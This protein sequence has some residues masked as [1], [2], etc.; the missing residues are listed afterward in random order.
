MKKLM[1]VG[2]V[3]VAAIGLFAADEDRVRWTGA[4]DSCWNKPSNWTP[5]R[6]PTADD[7][8]V[9][10][11]GADQSA[12][13]TVDTGSTTSVK[14]ID[15]VT[16]KITLT[17]TEGSALRFSATAK[18][19]YDSGII[20]R[21]G[22]ELLLECPLDLDIRFDTWGEGTV[23]FRSSI[24]NSST[25]SSYLAAMTNIF[26]TGTASFPSTLSCGL[27]GTDDG[28]NRMLVKVTGDAVL[29]V[30]ELSLS[31]NKAHVPV[32]FVIDGENAKVTTT[33][34]AYLGNYATN[35]S[36]QRLYV[37]NGTLTVGTDAF[38]GYVAKGAL[39][40]E[41]GAVTVNGNFVVGGTEADKTR[42]VASEGRVLVSGGT[43]AVGGYCRVGDVA[44]SS[45]LQSGGTVTV[46]NG[47]VLK[48]LATAATTFR[49][50]GGRF[51][52]SGAFTRPLGDA[53]GDAAFELA[54]GTFAVMTADVK[55]LPQ[56]LLVDGP[57][58][59]EVAS[60]KLVEIKRP[61]VF[62]ENAALVKAGA[63]KLKF[64]ASCDQV[65]GS[66]EIKAG[67]LFVS[68]SVNLSAPIGWDEPLDITVRN[69]GVL[70]LHK[71]TSR[72]LMPVDLTVDNGG[73]VYFTND[74]SAYNRGFLN[75]R[76]YT[77]EGESK[78]VGRYWAAPGATTGLKGLA[79][80]SAA[81]T[82]VWT[83][84]AG[85]N[86]W[87][88]PGNWNTG[89]V[90][91]GGVSPSADISA[92]TEIELDKE[93][94]IGCIVFTPNGA[95]RKVRLTGSQKL[96][97]C[98]DASYACGMFVSPDAEIELDVDFHR[99]NDGT[100]ALMGGGT[101]R[102]RKS[103][104]AAD[105]SGNPLLTYD[106]QPIFEGVKQLNLLSGKSTYNFLTAFS[107]ASECTSLLTIGEGTD[108]T[109][110]SLRPSNNGYT[111]WDGVRQVGGKATFTGSMAW[112]RH[113]GTART[114][115][116]YILEGGELVGTDYSMGT[117]ISSS[118]TRYPGAQFVM[119]GGSATFKTI[120]SFLHQ[121][122]ARL[123][124]GT[125]T[126]NGAGLSLN[127][128]WAGYDA[129]EKP[130]QL[131]GVT[132]VANRTDA[133]SATWFNGNV[134]LTGENGDTKIIC[135][136]AKNVAF[137]DGSVTGP[138]G[139]VKEGAKT[140]TF[141]SGCAF[142]GKIEVHEASC[143][144][145]G[146]FNGPSAILVTGGKFVFNSG[147]TAPKSPETI[148]LAATSSLEINDAAITLTVKRLTIA[149]VDQAPGEYAFKSGKVVVAR[150]SGT[151]AGG[152]GGN[153]SDTANWSGDVPDSS[154]SFVSPVDGGAIAINLDQAASL[155]ALTCDMPGSAELTVSGENAMTFPDGAVI[156]VAA[157]NALTLDAPVRVGGKVRKVG[158]GSIAFTG[159]IVA[160][161]ADPAKADA[162]HWLL[163]EDG[164][165]T[166]DCEVAGVRMNAGSASNQQSPSLTLGA[167]ADI[168]A[169]SIAFAA[170]TSDT[171]M[172]GLSNGEIRQTGGV[173]DY[174]N[175]LPAGMT[176]YGAFSDPSGGSARY[177]L[178]GGTLVTRNAYGSGNEDSLFRSSGGTGAGTMEFVQ[179]GGE[180]HFGILLI[181]RG[182]ASV[183]IVTLNGGTFNLRSHFGAAIGCPAYVN[184]NGGTFVSALDG[185]FLGFPVRTTIGGTVGFAQ[186]GT[187]ISSE[188]GADIEGSGAIVQKGPG[189]LVVSGKAEGVGSYAVE[190][191]ALELA[192]ATQPTNITVAAG[193]QLILGQRA[194]DAFDGTCDLAVASRLNAPFVCGYDGLAVVKSLTVGGKEKGAGYYDATLHRVEQSKACLQV[195]T[196]NGPGACIL[197]R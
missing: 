40:Q 177:V 157:G 85:D 171:G 46:G 99:S 124:G 16:G 50:E 48:T 79:A 17:A 195:L 57:A 138:G 10:S 5:Q 176:G 146:A 152:A 97:L 179:N 13:V 42:T 27:S 123:T 80:A 115:F 192:G 3:A 185:T 119:T 127:K 43:L 59:I 24:V 12:T 164:E 158:G 139:I 190:S 1:V 181:G 172:T 6:V 148:D 112:T 47:L 101:I 22:M 163:I 186:T 121:D 25:S 135:K 141:G 7:V 73:L 78:P 108:F 197:I 120:T 126:L 102:A 70:L 151:W 92:A 77:L 4:T 145:S 169:N 117:E 86:K 137:S 76:S 2:L 39:I 94:W 155:S 37:K 52:L 130:W 140:L 159:G 11:I 136:T 34:K 82:T 133:E 67:Q 15:V 72:L 142:T 103:W 109:A 62:T 180:S 118:W 96:Y 90:P 173:V 122:T 45:Y 19:G 36:E 107:Q 144:V 125:L 184:L 165:A 93:V 110:A 38:V 9:F 89:V 182:S 20:V 56:A 74:S 87:H 28:V 35:P 66:I 143:A 187:A 132:I 49:M 168:G 100:L 91:T 128:S 65:R 18:G 83:G 75:L 160:D 113:N 189:R 54:G 98:R 129:T 81:I 44:P 31:A 14:W 196:G 105:A 111:A 149:G 68:E 156:T 191:G 183:N 131:G 51:E 147:A 55:P 29:N 41:G 104:P 153:W 154:A 58:T 166:V 32:D 53:R 116:G 21:S 161:V 69:G 95:N 33:Y 26:E 134:E 178:D 60:D 170:S 150:D 23:R 106:C 8:A 88:T 61:M 193:A 194:A 64:S 114:P 71:L 30:K 84:A 63:G 162:T 167:N 174:S 188:I 175:G